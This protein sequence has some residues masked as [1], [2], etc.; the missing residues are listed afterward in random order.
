MGTRHLIIVYYKGEYRICQYGQFDGYPS[1][2]GVKVLGFVRDSLNVQKLKAAL[3]KGMI[4]TPTD[5]QV[6]AWEQED[7]EM[8]RNNQTDYILSFPVVTLDRDLSAGVLKAVVEAKE[9]VPIVCD[10][11]FICDG[12]FCEWAYVVDLDKNTLE[13]FSYAIDS[14]GIL[15]EDNGRF[16]GLIDPQSGARCR[17]EPIGLW[18]LD[19]LPE[20]DAFCERFGYTYDGPSNR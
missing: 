7:W 3:D 1:G 10:K 4:Y 9:P 20:N 8:R 5:E 14:K 19:A 13:V 6:Q 15:V 17:I 11:Y 12:L 2:Q 18:S 16:E